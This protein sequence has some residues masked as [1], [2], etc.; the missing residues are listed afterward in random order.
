MIIKNE[1]FLK[2][3]Q[4]FLFQHKKHLSFYYSVTT[5]LAISQGGMDMKAKK[6]PISSHCHKPELPQAALLLACSAPDKPYSSI[7][8]L[9]LPKV[10]NH[11]CSL[12]IQT[13]TTY[14]NFTMKPVHKPQTSEHNISA[15]NIQHTEVKTIYFWLTTQSLMLSL[16]LGFFPL[17][18]FSHFF[19]HCFH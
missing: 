14:S 18:T 12:N 1:A 10:W 19:Y 9:D 7:S 8:L 4:T 15:D 3:S 2:K 17:Y 16:T 6:G 11:S 5:S 13:S